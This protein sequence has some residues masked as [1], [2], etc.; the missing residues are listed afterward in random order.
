MNIWLISSLYK[1]I[2]LHDSRKW[3]CVFGWHTWGFDGFQR[4]YDCVEPKCDAW[5]WF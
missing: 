1:K 3:S 5:D 2:I 4:A